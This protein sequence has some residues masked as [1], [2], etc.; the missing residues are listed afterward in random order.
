MM[1]LAQDQLESQLAESLRTRV[2]CYEASLTTIA[3]IRRL[4]KENGNDESHYRRLEET[5]LLAVNEERR[6]AAFDAEFF[7][8]RKKAGPALQAELNRA[9]TT[10]AR[11]VNEIEEVHTAAKLRKET[12]EPQVKNQAKA[13]QMR[14][15]Y[16]SASRYGDTA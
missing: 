11:L 12:L 8:R 5:T 3:E 14:S 6:M 2:A 4:L 16:K 13:S 7:R 15:A 10:L 9:E 1:D